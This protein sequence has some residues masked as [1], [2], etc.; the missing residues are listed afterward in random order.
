MDEGQLWVKLGS[1]A[2]LNEGLLIPAVRK[3]G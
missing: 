3:Y 2:G 1:T